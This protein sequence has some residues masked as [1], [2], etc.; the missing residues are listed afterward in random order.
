M[1]VE[2]AAGDRATAAGVLARVLDLARILTGALV[3]VD[4]I[5]RLLGSVTNAPARGPIEIACADPGLAAASIALDLDG[6]PDAITLDLAPAA[7]RCQD[8][9]IAALTE[10][11]GPALA[12]PDD[13]L[14]FGLPATGSPFGAIAIA[15]CAG[16]WLTR[17]AVRRDLREA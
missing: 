8:A 10:A 2:L 12:A 4:Q 1:T 3:T 11:C 5:T 17:I 7:A 15:S 14:W 6:H 16:P 9:L 13:E